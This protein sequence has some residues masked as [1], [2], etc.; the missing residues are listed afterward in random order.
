M[1]HVSRQESLAIID[2]PSTLWLHVR[3][4]EGT[5]GYVRR[6]AVDIGGLPRTYTSDAR[7]R[8][9]QPSSDRH[10]LLTPFPGALRVSTALTVIAWLAL[11][12]G[13]L[14]GMGA[15]AAYDCGGAFSTCSNESS[16]RFVLYL[17]FAGSGLATALTCWV[18]A[19][20]LL[21]LDAIRS[22]TASRA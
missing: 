16:A 18:G 6:D 20:A 19:Y 1:R 7:P 17:T 13:Q 5:D 12:G 22:N 8:A 9:D 15:A 14:I 3:L 10:L 21:L 2:E 4:S 11:I